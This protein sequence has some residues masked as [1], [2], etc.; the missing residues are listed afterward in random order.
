MG[1]DVALATCAEFPALSPDDQPLLEELRRRGLKAE[2]VVWNAPG[3]DWSQPKVCVLRSTWDY[4]T[5]LAGFLTWAERVATVTAL[6]NPWEVILW[7]THKSYLRSL[8]E[9]GVAVAPTVWL[10]AGGRADLPGL[11]AEHGWADA[12]VK[13]VVALS[14]RE[15]IRVSAHSRA[16][17]QSHLDRVLAQEA[18]MVQPFFEAVESEGELSL[19]FIEGEFTHAIRKRPATGD[20]RVQHEYGGSE[21]RVEPSGEELGLGRAA[22]GAAGFETL[23]A[24]ADVM[25]GNDGQLCLMELEL[26]EPSLFFEHA[27]EAAG[28]LAG[29]IEAL[30]RL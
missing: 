12:V 26:V 27:P 24:R 21:E 14:A 7:N 2:P 15:T 23:Y 1:M 18:V 6:W 16:E 28:R 5:R 22:L 17:A 8:A 13:P 29:G 20:F 4:T 10:A 3:F 19:L 30:Y 11:M 9:A 25:R